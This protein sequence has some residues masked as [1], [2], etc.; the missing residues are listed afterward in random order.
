MSLWKNRNVFVTGAG[1]LRFVIPSLGLSIFAWACLDP[2]FRDAEGFLRSA[3]CLLLSVS[4]ALVTLGLA[5]RTRFERSAF[6]FSLALVGQAMA[7]QM[8]EAGNLLRYQHYRPIDPHFLEVH[9]W[10]LLFLGLQGA[11]VAWGLK[12]WWSRIRLWFRKTFK[13]WQIAGIFLVFFLTSATVSPEVSRYVAELFFAAFVQAVN[14]GN[15][16]LLVWAIPEETLASL[17][18]KFDRFFGPPVGQALEI[19]DS[20]IPHSAIR[21][22]KLKRSG[23]DRFAILAACWVFVAASMLNI[24]VYERHPHI[25]DE[26]IYLLHARIL[27]KG[28]LTLPAPPVPEAFEVYLMQ[29]DG[30]RWYPSPPAGWP[31]V[32]AVGVLFGVPWL[33][34]PVLAGIN[35]LMI[36]WIIWALYTRRHARMVVLLLCLSPW[37]I[38]M[39]MSFEGHHA[40]LACALFATFGVIKA[41]QHHLALWAWTAGI[42]LGFMSLIRPLDGLVIALL[43]GLWSIGLGGRRLK[44]S[45]LSGLVLGTVL[46]GALVLPYNQA[47]TGNPTVFPIELFHDT[48]YHPKAFSYGFGPER[49]MG[50]PIDPNPGHGPID[51]LINSSLNAFAINIE[52]FGWSTGSLLLIALMAFSGAYRRSD[53]LMMAV[54]VAVFVAHFFY[55]FSG[56]PD[57]GARYWYLMIVPL[58]ALS[59]RGLDYLA[60]KLRDDAMQP[61]LTYERIV[62]GSFLACAITMV[63]FFPWRAIDKYHHYL[64]MRPDIL[65][66]EKKYHFNR[67]LVLI[68]GLNRPDYASAAHYNPLDLKSDQPIYAWDRSPEVRKRVLEAYPD[69]V[70]WIVEGPTL[71]GR[72]YEVV[73]GPLNP[74]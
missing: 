64:D 14:L 24:I 65:K 9:W 74:K 5:L 16:V 39:A 70:V 18:Q 45:S 37:Y 54:L 21:N 35:I 46:V 29:P 43:L 23:I 58:T 13:W 61:R 15:I 50:W 68:R 27:S 19:A 53:Y 26:I 7:L 3:F 32:L 38:F 60:G 6:W 71:T 30:N 25:T 22:P 28:E 52:L 51:G 33:V 73:A 44:I 20:S 2:R 1:Y 48:Y 67:S 8:I 62:V 55:F 31:A 40:T 17:Q 72:S 11:L 57:F 56:G 4:F 10:K 34:N 36:Y 49:G 66:L 42:A 63:T 12:T 47:L 41:R 69:R 59:V